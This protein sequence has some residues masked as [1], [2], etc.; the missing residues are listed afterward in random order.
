MA[1]TSDP[2]SG[3]IWRKIDFHLH[4][5]GSSSFR[6]PSGCDLTTREGRQRVVD[7]YVER[8]VG[9]GIEIAC[10]TDYQAV[11]EDWFSL[12]RERAT[13]EGISVLPGAEVSINR[14][15]GKGVH[16]LLVCDPSTSHEKINNALRH[17]DQT[18]S[19][20]VDGRNQHRDIDLRDPLEKALEE[21]RQ[22]LGC[23]LLAA[24]ADGDNGVLKRLGPAQTAKIGRAHV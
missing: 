21:L 13:R 15:A 20:L 2:S 14:G 22:T 9:A 7:L 5:P 18:G 8:L 24:H 12:I 23:V 4:T 6:L 19:P 10:L 1:A 11:R 17:I 16:L 3:A